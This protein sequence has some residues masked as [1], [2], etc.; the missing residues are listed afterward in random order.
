[1][2]KLALIYDFMNV[3]SLPSHSTTHL[4]EGSSGFWLVDTA[5]LEDSSVRPPRIKEDMTRLHAAIAGGTNR[6]RIK[7]QRSTHRLL[8]G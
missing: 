4:P 8:W 6:L 5:T 1:M 2:N 7:F 3:Q